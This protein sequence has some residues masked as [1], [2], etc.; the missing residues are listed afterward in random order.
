MPEL[1]GYITLSRQMAM[2]RQMEVIANNLSNMSSTGYKS[3]SVLFEEYLETTADG[4]T[5]SYVRDYGTSRDLSEGEFMATENPM[6]VAITKGGYMKVETDT[7]MYY[8]RN[9]NL[10]LDAT[11]QLVTDEG[12]PILDDGEQPIILT[13]EDPTLTIAKDGTISNS[14]GPLAKL[15]IVSFE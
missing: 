11:G 13:P 7:G 9:G 10:R 4:D 6:D 8:T 12:F 3:E 2:E 1:T 5:I 15:A 14:Q